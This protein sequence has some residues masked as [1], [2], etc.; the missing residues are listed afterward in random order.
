MGIRRGFGLGSWFD[1]N[2]VRVEG[3]GAK[4]FF[5]LDQW[6]KGGPLRDRWHLPL[7]IFPDITIEECIRTFSECNEGTASENRKEL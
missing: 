7:E 3:V 4:M 6:L 2:L 1:D 5:W